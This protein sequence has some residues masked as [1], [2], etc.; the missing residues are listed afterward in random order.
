MSSARA[1]RGSVRGSLTVAF[2][3]PRL[4]QLALTCAVAAVIGGLAAVP[5]PSAAQGPAHVAPTLRAPEQLATSRHF[6]LEPA[7]S[8][9]GE[10]LLLSEDSTRNFVAARPLRIWRRG[11]R[12]LRSVGVGGLALAVSNAGRR[13]EYEC[14]RFA[15]CIKQLGTT[16]I[17][18]VKLPCGTRTFPGVFPAAGLGALLVDCE[19]KEPG[20]GPVDVTKLLK[21]GP[22]SAKVAAV[23]TDFFAEDISSDGSTF[24]VRDRHGVQHLYRR[25]HLSRVALPEHPPPSLSLNGRYSNIEGPGK[26]AVA[27]RESGGAVIPGCTAEVVLPTVLDLQNGSTRALPFDAGAPVD[28]SNDGRF[29]CRWP[30]PAKTSACAAPCVALKMTDATTGQSA[31]LAT[32]PFGFNRYL[33]SADASTVAYVQDSPAQELIVVTSRP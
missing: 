1:H 23:F 12:G 9:N 30:C 10:W 26:V 33:M 11:R 17:Q 25:G 7:L 29:D 13:I 31:T 4:R 28:I 5:T 24:L 22:T 19:A 3:T 14:E 15:V 27:C 18:R 16:S 2:S 32:D 8:T 6:L 20:A 21:I